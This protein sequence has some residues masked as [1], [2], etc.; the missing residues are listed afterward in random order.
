MKPYF[1]DAKNWEKA[2]T[3][4]DSWMGTPYRHLWMQKGRGADCALFIGAWLQELGIVKEVLHDFY[5]PNWF[6]HTDLEIIKNVFSKNIATQMVDNFD[7]QLI[8]ADAIGEGVQLFRGDMP[9]FCTVPK[10]GI[11]NHAG[12]MLD[13]GGSF[14]HSAV[15]R[16]VSQMHWGNYWRRCLTSVYRVVVL[17]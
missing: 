6:L 12:I 3:V 10:R 11:T 16:G 9:T 1:E 15:N 4:L 2:K 7:L 5:P 8:P 17:S 14:I 13:G